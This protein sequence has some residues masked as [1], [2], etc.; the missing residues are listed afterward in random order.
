M[1]DHDEP[2]T[3]QSLL[4]CESIAKFNHA[5]LLRN[6]MHMRI[7]K[8]ITFIIRI[9][10]FSMAVV[11]VAFLLL[12]VVLSSRMHVMVDTMDIMNHHFSSMSDN[13]AA[14]N[15]VIQKMDRNVGAMSAIVSEVQRMD[16]AVQ[17]LHQSV[18]VIS[19][20]LSNMTDNVGRMG[21][22]VARMTGNFQQMDS[23]V[24]GI[25]YDVNTMSQPMKVFDSF[26]SM[27]PMP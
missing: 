2:T 19:G 1:S 27:M 9:G 8:R 11:A 17:T 4:L 18:A 13:M 12:M 25:G 26:R 21:N 15:T 7:G 23:S 20:N 14:M 3:N 10:M 16:V 6:E 5:V 24:Y 22:N